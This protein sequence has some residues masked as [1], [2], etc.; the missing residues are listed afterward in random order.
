MASE[1]TEEATKR[2]LTTASTVVGGAAGSGLAATAG[3][4]L[5]GEATGGTILGTLAAQGVVSQGA[6][7]LMAAHPVTL[8]ALGAGAGLYGAYKLCKRLFD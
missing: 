6:L 8:M 7:V 1:R 4:V 3:A 2:A 5:A